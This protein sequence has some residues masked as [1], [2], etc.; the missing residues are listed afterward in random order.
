MT[1]NNIVKLYW[2]GFKLKYLFI[3]SLFIIR[4]TSLK[5]IKYSSIQQY[6]NGQETVVKSVEKYI[7]FARL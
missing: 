1:V 3:I 2:L 4:G 5:T 6:N 7:I